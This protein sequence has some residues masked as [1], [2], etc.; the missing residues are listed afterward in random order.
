MALLND[1]LTWTETLPAWQR[2]AAR[3]LFQ[4][5][6]GLS[7]EDYSELYA[8]LKASRGLPCKDGLS[9]IPLA[10]QHLPAGF[11][12]SETVILKAMHELTNV[13]RIAPDQTLS[14][15]DTGITVIY[16]G[17]G[18]GKSGYA[19]VL[20]RACRARDQQEKVLPNA[21]DA[22]AR[23]ATPSAKFDIEIASVAEEALWSQDTVPPDK[24]STIAVFDSKCARSYLTA[25]QDVA[26]LP[27]GLDIVENLA[28]KVLPELERRLDEET[29]GINVDT[30]PFS[31]L[32]GQTRVGNLISSLSYRTGKEE[33]EKLG[34]LSENEKNRLNELKKILAEADPISKAEDM[35]L[36]ARRFKEQGE[37]VAKPLA[38][39][40]DKMLEKLQQLDQ[41]VVDAEEAEAKAA[42]VLRSG[43][44]LL[45]GTGG[46]TWKL[47]F[48]A[49]RRYSTE[50]AYPEHSFPHVEDARCPLCQEQ[51]SG[52][53]GERLKRFEQYIKDDVAKVAYEERKKLE[54]ARGKIEKADLSIG[55]DDAISSEIEKLDPSIISVAMAYYESIENRRRSMLEALDTHDWADIPTIAESPRLAIRGLAARQLK[56][57]RTLLKSAD[58]EKKKC[59]ESE[60][61]E[62]AAR[63]SLSKSLS[64]VLEL[65]QRM[66]DKKALEDC[67]PSL[68]T[69]PI[70]DKS[71]ELASQTVTNELKAALDREF[72]NLGVGHIKTNLKERNDHG[73]ILHQLV[74][75]VPTTSKIEDVLSEGEQRA[76]ALGAFLAELSLANHSCG[77]VFD[78]PVTSLDHNRR[79]RVAKRLVHEANARQVIVFTHEVVFLQGLCSESEQQGVS[80]TYCFLEPSTSHF[81]V[82]QNGLPWMH[83]SVVDRID[84]L[85]KEQ[86]RLE[87]LPW[88]PVPS[89]QLANKIVHLYSLLRATI[90]RVVQDCMLNGT[91]K[92]YDRYIRVSNLEG[93]LVL[94]KSD[95]DE[96]SGLNQRCHDII[97]AHDP[98][99][100]AN[101]PP[102]TPNDL[103]TDI[104]DLS[105]LIQRIKDRR[106]NPPNLTGTSTP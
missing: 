27:Y 91:V 56:A 84:A 31:H 25:E 34:A 71:K 58:P 43:E 11:A 7:E 2:D 37:K 101:N 6:G 85:E 78:D 33:I 92:R 103:K 9:A 55:M 93:V 70:S 13:N 18:S 97:D 106:R 99:S 51:I 29:N 64:A 46:K 82:V 72:S 105:A 100:A 50:V 73:K 3:R 22:S 10:A 74:L 95:F 17:N 40:S 53:T 67:K 26:Y 77:I 89:E 21:Q 102:P 98:A 44:E 75:D 14:F 96:I 19:R 4:K 15:G 86:R 61:N 39:V 48:E 60:R 80:S 5:E 45:D 76:I 87:R 59:L 28:N 16:G 79:S 49:A 90:E 66:K 41:S 38:W 24:L 81:G 32:V 62:L 88:P 36:A 47:L 54:I 42:E 94:Q 63:E 12:A 30:I 35:I 8:L 104:S 52:A 83:K 1:I 65:L 23:N 69:K 57:A 68:R 20:K